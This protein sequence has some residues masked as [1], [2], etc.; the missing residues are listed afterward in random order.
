MIMKLPLVSSKISSFCFFFSIM[1]S[2]EKTYMYN[3]KEKQTY[4]YLEISIEC[5]SIIQSNS[6]FQPSIEVNASLHKRRE[7]FIG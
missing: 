1:I 2:S 3:M 4:V 5:N 7:L 6:H